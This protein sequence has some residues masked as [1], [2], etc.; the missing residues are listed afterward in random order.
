MFTLMK[1]TDT[2]SG[3]A[4]KL[5][6]SSTKDASAVKGFISNYAGDELHNF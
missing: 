6:V 3:I 5:G 2:V 4:A 1:L